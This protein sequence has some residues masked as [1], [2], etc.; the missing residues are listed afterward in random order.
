MME[1]IE[2]CLSFPVV[3]F[4]GM[5]VLSALYWMVAAFGLIDLDSFD[6]DVDLDVGGDGLDLG[7]VG[8]GT[9]FDV[10]AVKG[11]AGLGG[12]ASLMFQLGLYGVPITLILTF[13]SL[14]GWIICFYAAS[15]LVLP[16]F[17]PGLIRYAI[18]IP[19]FTV[20]FVAGLLL[21]AQ[22]IKP[23]RRLFKKEEQIT[24]AS[25]CGRVVLIRSSQVTSTYGEAVYED[26][27]AGMLLDVRPAHE[28]E[29]FKRGDKAVLLSYDPLARTYS[30]IS[31]DEFRRG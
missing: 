13:I 26:G 27:G 18:G 16:F 7:D 6:I 23:F 5:L 22:A 10:S 31:E 28:G 19:V 1:F 15:L 9:D 2:T 8:D 30:I 29:I 20:S 21:T 3:I 17:S 11:A 12:F 24:A 25:I 4:S 14:I